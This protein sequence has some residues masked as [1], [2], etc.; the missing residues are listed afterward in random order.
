[1]NIKELLLK[2]KVQDKELALK[3]ASF[4]VE[5]PENF[6]NLMQCFLDT[7]HRLAQRAAWCVSWAAKKNPQMITPHLSALVA[8]LP[9][10]DVHDAVIRNSL[11]IL[12]AVEIP[13]T[14][15]GEVMDACFKLIETHE[16][17]VAIKAFALT[18]L[19]NLTKFYPEIKPEL[20]LVIEERKEHETIAFRARANKI[21]KFLSK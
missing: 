9:R 13:E 19:Y 20:K 17:P 1:M 8:Q 3:I 2:E 11:R 4:A 7:D 6:D 10:K 18:T 16:T 5:S 15:H 21:I 14:L 12:E